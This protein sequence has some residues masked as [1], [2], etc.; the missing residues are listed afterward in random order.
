MKFLLPLIIFGAANLAHADLFPFNHDI[1]CTALAANAT[2]VEGDHSSVTLLYDKKAHPELGRQGEIHLNLNT[3]FGLLA[4]V[5]DQ[6]GTKKP[7]SRIVRTE[8]PAGEVG[9]LLLQ[10]PKDPFVAKAEITFSKIDLIADDGTG[11]TIEKSLANYITTATFS[12]ITETA[13]NEYTEK[14]ETHEYILFE[15]DGGLSGF[16]NYVVKFAPSDCHT[17]N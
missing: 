15:I 16:G 3:G 1:T 5:A 6:I 11:T 13:L 8:G 10:D 2:G 7:Y 4:N 12:R 9:N 17:L 14:S